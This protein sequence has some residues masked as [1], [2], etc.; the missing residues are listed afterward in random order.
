MISFLQNFCRLLAFMALCAM[1]VTNIF[2]QATAMTPL[3]EKIKQKLNVLF[4][5][6]QYLIDFQGAA[7]LLNNP[8]S[9]GADLL[10]G[11]AM[12]GVFQQQLGKPFTGQ[13]PN[14]SA[15][16]G[17]N[18]G[19]LLIVIDRDI[20]ADRVRIAKEVV[21]RIIEGEGL[22][23][24][25]RLEVKQQSILKID[26]R[27]TPAP[28]TK[29][30]KPQPSLFELI[31]QKSDLMTK[32]FLV[33]WAAIISLMA[34]YVFLKRLVGQPPSQSKVD[35][36]EHGRLG[37]QSSERSTNSDSE[38]ADSNKKKFAAK[39]E[40]LYSKDQA[41]LNLIQ[42]IVSEA[43]NDPKK[44]SKI[45]T[46]WV[47]QSEDF[48]RFA[49]VF[50]KNCDIR[51]I[52]NICS[53][54][55]PSDLEKILSK[56]ILDFD[57]F[58]E[59]NQK[60][61][62][63]MR[64]DLALMAAEQILKE[65]PDP[66]DFLRLLSD[67]EV[68]NV[69]QDES[70]DTVALVST[71][72]PSHRLQNFFSRLSDDKLLEVVT[73]ISQIKAPSLDDFNAVRSNLAQKSEKMSSSLFNDKARAET[74]VQFIHSVNSPKVQIDLVAQL[75]KE[76]T[77]LLKK[78]RPRILLAND[79]NQVPSRMAT[80]L[81]QAIDAD[82]FATA[83]SNLGHNFTQLQDHFPDAYRTVFSDTITRTFEK[84]SAALAWQ[85]VQANINE[86]LS[87]GLLTQSELDSTIIQG[88]KNAEEQLSKNISVSSVYRGA[89]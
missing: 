88:E 42:E 80:V 21:S 62:D 77:N 10:P 87:N 68:S 4:Y 23:N 17:M 31:E 55:H 8:I 54:L 78:I 48:T 45:L 3:E 44:I 13:S 46:R 53:L 30:E 64:A 82:L 79:L 73:K 70:I 1:S 83:L 38:T 76:N 2:A 39:K 28:E 18:S 59:E 75:R 57:P 61:L 26:P 69:L 52:E 86:L 35:L 66:L 34:C 12:P 22:K 37:S 60:V 56:N 65:R 89:A 81:I 50:L 14:G 25:V 15:N 40:E 41:H 32:I 71:Q 19:D 24:S 20:S 6:D 9:N 72:I 33:V 5:E 58:S 27:Q 29:A 47:A 51:T 74:L 36:H 7:Q 84:E 63:R 85:K 43:K 11:L 67:E 16:I 49:S